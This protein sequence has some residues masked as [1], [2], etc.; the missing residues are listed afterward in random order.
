MHVSYR[1]CV[2]F[3]VIVS[4]SLFNYGIIIIPFVIKED[5]NDFILV[6][7]SKIIIFLRITWSQKGAENFFIAS[8]I[9]S[10][11]ANTLFIIR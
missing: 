7:Q 11:T 8:L 4:L 9:E 6:P 2:A 1:E 5:Q 3:E 10:F